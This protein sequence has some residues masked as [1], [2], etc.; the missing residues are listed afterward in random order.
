VGIGSDGE[1]LETLHTGE[2]K[3]MDLR[4]QTNNHTFT[5]QFDIQDR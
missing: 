4:L 2:L 1:D 5:I 3:D